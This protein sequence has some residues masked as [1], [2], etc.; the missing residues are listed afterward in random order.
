MKRLLFSIL[1]ISVYSCSNRV[2]QADEESVRKVVHDFVADFNDGSFK[3]ADNYTTIDWDHIN[4]GGG[5]DIGRESTLKTVRAV[6][7]SFLKGVSMTTDSM[8]VRFV[9]PEV[10]L[11]TGYHSIDTYVTPDSVRHE[12]ERQIKSYV[13]VKQK[14]KWLLTLDHNTSIK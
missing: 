7:Q 10:A 6:H 1:I 2:T 11:V 14:G 5:I 9:T 4:P 3:N 8:K 13:I 12:N